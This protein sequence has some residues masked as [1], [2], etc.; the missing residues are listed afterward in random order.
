M[1]FLVQSRFVCSWRKLHF[2]HNVI[3]CMYWGKVAICPSTVLQ[4]EAHTLYNNQPITGLIQRF[5]TTTI[6]PLLDHYWYIH[7]YIASIIYF[8]PIM[9]VVIMHIAYVDRSHNKYCSR[10]S[11]LCTLSGVCYKFPLW[12]MY[13]YC[14]FIINRS[15]AN[16]CHKMQYHSTT[17]VL[18][19][20]HNTV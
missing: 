7:S 12:A 4:L 13:A 11:Q 5:T 14:T 20:I 18:L 16:V 17:S 2:T 3:A 8:I 6:L 1:H 10:Y 9:N 15:R 19:I